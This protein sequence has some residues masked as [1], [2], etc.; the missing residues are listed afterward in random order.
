MRHDFIDRHS[1]LDSPVHR[2]P[3]WLKGLVLLL[4]VGVLA[5]AHR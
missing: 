3:T 4:L 1:R 5:A 2:L